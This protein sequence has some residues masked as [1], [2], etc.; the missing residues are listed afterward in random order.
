MPI[1]PTNPFKGRQT[2]A[3]ILGTLWEEF[4]ILNVE[5]TISDAVR[6]PLGIRLRLRNRNQPLVT[7][8]IRN[9]S[10]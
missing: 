3:D 9:T 1:T 8:E 4:D 10:S 2:R 6:L 5:E 7:P